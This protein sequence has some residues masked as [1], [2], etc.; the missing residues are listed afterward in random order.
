MHRLDVDLILG[1]RLDLKT[2][3]PENAEYDKRGRR[4]V[5]TE[6]GKSICADFVVS[7][8]FS[9]GGVSVSLLV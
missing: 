7:G 1:Q 2:T 8:C 6:S 9:P 5:K 4:V 3:L